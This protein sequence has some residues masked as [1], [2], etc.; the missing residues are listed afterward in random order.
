MRL[1]LYV[2]K[3]DLEGSSIMGSLCTY[4][5]NRMYHV[6]LIWYWFHFIY[7]MLVYTGYYDVDYTCYYDVWVKGNDY[8]IFTIL[9]G[10]CRVMGLHIHIA[11]EDLDWGYE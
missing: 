8:G 5:M 9:L 2:E 11:L 7:M 1:Y 10:L 4:V 6:G 3:D